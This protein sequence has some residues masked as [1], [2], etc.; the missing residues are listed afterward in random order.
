[1]NTTY[2][3]Q[4]NI[5]Y[6]YGLENYIKIIFLRAGVLL[7]ITVLVLMWSHIRIFQTHET[8]LLKLPEDDP[9]RGPK[10]IAAIK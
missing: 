1:M 9:K 8:Y 6:L 2:S 5:I 10:Y 4:K 3:K 7:M